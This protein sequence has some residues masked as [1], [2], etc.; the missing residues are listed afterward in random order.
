MNNR[1]YQTF[2]D[3]FNEIEGNGFRSE[4]VYDE[5][6]EYVEDG[7]LKAHNIYLIKWLK[8]A[9]EAGKEENERY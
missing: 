1:K 4:R 9:F 5:S 3:W 8:A 7:L 6:L 2:E